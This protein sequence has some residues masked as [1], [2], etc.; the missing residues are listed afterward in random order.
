MHLF[1]V[2][3]TPER[4]LSNACNAV[5]YCNACKLGAIEERIIPNACNAVGDCY[6]CKAGAIIESTPSNACN[7]TRDNSILA[8][9]NK[10]IAFGL[11]YCIA[12]LPAVIFAIA[13]LYNNACKPGA[14]FVFTT[15]YYSIF[16]E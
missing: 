5:R 15:S 11:Y 7:A 16:C 10:R 2:I 12:I 13:T 14:I 6:A 8:T 9:G 4:P 1:K 3:A